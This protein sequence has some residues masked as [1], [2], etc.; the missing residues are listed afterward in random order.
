LKQQRQRMIENIPVERRRLRN[1][2]EVTIKEFT[3]RMSG[4]RIRV[5]GNFKTSLFAY[6]VAIGINFGGI[7]R[8]TQK[9]E[10]RELVIVS[11]Y[12]RIFTRS[13]GLWEKFRNQIEYLVKSRI[14]QGKYPFLIKCSF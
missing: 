9:N 7:R 3:C 4:K 6:G 8:F 11:I 2:V 14:L 13:A 1:N 5:R 12:M 10:A